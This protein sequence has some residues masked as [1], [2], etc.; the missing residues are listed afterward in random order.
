MEKLIL[1]LPYLLLYLMHMRP[2]FLLYQKVAVG[3]LIP[4]SLIRALITNL[5][6]ILIKNLVSFHFLQNI[7][8]EVSDL[9]WLLLFPETLASECKQESALFAKY[10]KKRLI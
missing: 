9:K 4:A 1:R 7:E 10:A 8:N 3:K 6:L 5:I 2:Y